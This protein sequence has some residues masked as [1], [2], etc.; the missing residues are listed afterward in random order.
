M[1]R[2]QKIAVYNLVVFG[3]ALLLAT[4]AIIILYCLFGWQ[5]ATAG[6]A[7]LGIGGFGGLA[8]FI[9]KKDAG[10]VTCDERDILINRTAALGGFV[11]AYLWFCLVGTIFIFL[12]EPEVLKRLGLPVLIFGGGFVVW[13]VHSIMILVQYGRSKNY[14]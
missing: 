6:M 3:T 8:P 12:F 9:F 10:K 2:A 11:T 1:N 7:F 13:I 14:E 5:I 4:V